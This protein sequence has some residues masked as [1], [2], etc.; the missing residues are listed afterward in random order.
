MKRQAVFVAL[1]LLAAAVVLAGVQPAMAG[2]VFISIGTGGTG[3]TYFSTGG[4]VA[5]LISRECPSIKSA[6]AEVTAASVENAKLVN[7]GEAD[8]GMVAWISIVGDKLTDQLPNLRTLWWIHGSDRQWIVP[9]DS[10]IKT[11]RDFKGKTV[12]VGAPASATEV[13][14]QLE[15]DFF[16]L[17]YKDITPAYLSFSEGV[18][19]LKD[20]RVDVALVMAGFPNASVT[21]VA[22]LRK[23]RI[24][25]F[26]PED[27]VALEKK[28]PFCPP[29]TIPAGT[30]PGQDQDVHTFTTPGPMAINK[31]IPEETAYEIVKAAHQNQ[32]KLASTVHAAFKLWRFDPSV[33][34]L[35]PLHPG[36]A[37]YY[38]EIGLLK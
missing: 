23:V 26:S 29:V 34:A 10:P 28:Y 24:L 14:S 6:T 7:S 21:D 30:Y 12:V 32:E 15:L 3:G 16:G 22:T 19:A 2:D 4:A 9:A 5:D 33:G 37:R 31:D 1:V 13:T 38:K 11:P 25:N 20:N 35:A 27:L 8:M 36:A 18:E 17:S